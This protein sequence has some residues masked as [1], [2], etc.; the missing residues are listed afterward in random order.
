MVEKFKPSSLSIEDLGL[1]AAL[2]LPAAVPAAP[3]PGYEALEKRLMQWKRSCVERPDDRF[4]KEEFFAALRELVAAI[5]AASPG[6]GRLPGLK[7][8]ANALSRDL[9]G[10]DWYSWS[11]RPEPPPKLIR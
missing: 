9:H 4:A 2:A 1:E 8:A 5:E 7:R 11:D 10:R 3:V 6:D